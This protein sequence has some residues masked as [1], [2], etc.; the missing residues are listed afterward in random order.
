VVFDQPGLCPSA[1]DKGRN[2]T[3]ME[4]PCGRVF[5]FAPEDKIMGKK[6]SGRG[7]QRFNIGCEP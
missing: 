3:V 6:I 7:Y 2:R 1:R 5:Y 4:T